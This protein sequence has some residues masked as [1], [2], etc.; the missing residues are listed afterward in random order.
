MNFELIKSLWDIKL[1]DISVKF[2]ETYYYAKVPF[3]PRTQG[4]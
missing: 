3:L 4:K 2:P 1:F